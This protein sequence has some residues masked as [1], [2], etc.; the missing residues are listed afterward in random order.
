VNTPTHRA[1]HP[2]DRAGVTPGECP[3]E[4]E[5]FHRFGRLRFDNHIDEEAAPPHGHGK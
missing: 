3:T 4:L 2:Y 5:Y 1:C